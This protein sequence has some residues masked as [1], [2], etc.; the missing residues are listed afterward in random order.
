MSCIR[1]KSNRSNETQPTPY[2]KVEAQ[3]EEKLMIYSGE[4][5]QPPQ[6]SFCAKNS[7]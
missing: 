3:A 7:R 1:E 4:R 5:I 2:E 6:H